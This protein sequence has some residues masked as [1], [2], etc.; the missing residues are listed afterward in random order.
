MYHVKPWDLHRFLYWYCLKRTLRRF[1]PQPSHWGFCLWTRETLAWGPISKH[2]MVLGRIQ[3]EDA[4]KVSHRDVRHLP[5]NH[6]WS[7]GHT[8]PVV[9]IPLTVLSIESSMRSS[10]SPRFKLSKI[11]H[12]YLTFNFDRSLATSLCLYV[13]FPPRTRSM[14]CLL[15]A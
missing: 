12:E 13:V 4:T 8:F 1:W 14:S 6:C 10:T 3:P 7:R 5:R 11:Q 15:E 9:T 2:R